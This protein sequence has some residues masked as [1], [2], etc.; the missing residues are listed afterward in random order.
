MD[1]DPG[2]PHLSLITRTGSLR[3]GDGVRANVV[4]EPVKSSNEFAEA[5][6]RVEREDARVAAVVTEP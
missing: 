6:N 5:E 4:V 2:L 3:L 1:I